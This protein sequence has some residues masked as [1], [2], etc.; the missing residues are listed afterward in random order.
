MTDNI[1]NNLISPSSE[2]SP[3]PFWF[4]NDDLKK[5]EIIRQI[6]DMH[7]KEVD[8]FVIH[9][10]IGI[11]ES[12]GYMSKEYL[13][14]VKCAVEEAAANN[15]QVVLYDEGMYPSG[16]AHG[17]VAEENPRYKSKGLKVVESSSREFTPE[18]NE[19]LICSLAAKKNR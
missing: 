2:Y 16:S 8:G 19:I 15:M 9:P 6:R 3:I 11:P 12:I 4:W 17:Q 13:Q 14:F 10:R 18:E 1:R 5:D 7:S